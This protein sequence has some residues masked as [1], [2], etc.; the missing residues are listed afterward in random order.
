MTRAVVL[1]LTLCSSIAAAEVVD[2]LEVHAPGDEPDGYVAAGLVWDYS[3]GFAERGPMV[4][5]G[6]RIGTS[7]LFARAMGQA[8]AVAR[9]DDPGTGTFLELRGGLE[10]RTCGSGGMVCASAGL[11]LGYRNASFDH[12][13]YA[14]DGTY[15]RLDEGLDAFVAVP[16]LTFDA[17]GRARFRATFEL[18]LEKRVGES[19]MAVAA[20]TSTTMPPTTDSSFG[21]GYAISI[22]LAV[23]F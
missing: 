14:L 23:G 4:E 13:I 20:R 9:S 21:A 22:A 16:R 11:D 7:A 1:A 15:T 5:V 3:H 6:K 2:P 8:G 12:K 10:G 17:G 19:Q 18:P